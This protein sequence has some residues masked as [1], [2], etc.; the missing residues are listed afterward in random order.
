[1]STSFR[2]LL[3]QTGEVAYGRP[4]PLYDSTYETRLRVAK[5]QI[6]ESIALTVT[7][8]TKGAISFDA[9]TAL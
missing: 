5:E 3:T 7:E 4:E 6:P 2:E 1:A 9:P 8:L